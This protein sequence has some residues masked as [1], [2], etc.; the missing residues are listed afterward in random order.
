MNGKSSWHLITSEEIEQIRTGLQDVRT[1]LLSN[2]ERVYELL[3]VI[4]HVR[5]RLA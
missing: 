1:D 3:S 2:P 4:E 5:D